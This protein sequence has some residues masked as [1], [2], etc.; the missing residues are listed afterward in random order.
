MSEFVNCSLCDW[1]H[2]YM[3][4]QPEGFFPPDTKYLVSFLIPLLSSSNTNWVSNSST[5][6]DSIYL[7]LASDPM[8]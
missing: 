3:R 1:H 5:Q 4:Y 6:P 7:V 2:T 8:S